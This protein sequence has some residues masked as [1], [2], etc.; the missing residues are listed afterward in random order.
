MGTAN[1]AAPAEEAVFAPGLRVEIRD[2]EWVIKRADLTSSGSHSLLV[3]GISEI[4]RGKEARFLT[5][6]DT[7]KPLH[8][9]DTELVAD[10]S[11]KFSAT[12]LY[13]ESLLRQSP[14]T[15]SDLWIGHCAAIDVLPY[16]LDPAIQALGHPKQRQLVRMTAK[17]PL[18]VLGGAGTGKTVIAMHRA[19]YLAEEVFTDREDRI[20]FTTFT[21]N[22]AT[23]ISQ[24]LRKLCTDE[25]AWARIEVKHLDGWVSNFLR[26]QGYRPGVVYDEDNDAWKMAVDQAPSI[27]GLPENFYRVEWE[28]VI[29]AQNITTSDQYLA[30]PR[31][32]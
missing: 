31:L 21:T 30:A 16:Q 29:Q 11:P 25:R 9:E 13:L 27:S 5:E 6:I 18:R 19:R 8:P 23:D 17:G 4:V 15:D 32:P 3:T 20:L 22:L 26:T 24:N 2:A 10:D 28:Q 12:R 1:R 14:P 7:V